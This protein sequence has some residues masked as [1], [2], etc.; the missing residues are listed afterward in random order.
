MAPSACEDT[1]IIGFQ[2]NSNDDQFDQ[3]FRRLGGNVLERHSGRRIDAFLAGEYPFLTRS[4]W[5]RRLDGGEVL[6]NRQQ[7]RSSYRMRIGDLVHFYHPEEVEPEVSR[8]VRILWQDGGVMAVFKPGNLPMHENGAYRKNTFAKLLTDLVGGEWSAVHRL[9]RETSGIVLCGANHKVRQ[10]LSDAFEA[11]SIQKEYLCIV[12]GVPI[13]RQWTNQGSLGDLVQSRIRIKKWV[14]EGGLP[15]ETGFVTEAEANGYSL[16]R[17]FPRT[18]RTNQIRIHAAHSGHWILGDKLYHP[19]EEVFLDYW[20]KGETTEFVKDKT[21][22]HR[23]CLHAAALSF[24]HPETA[25]SYRIDS[26]LPEDMQD[27]WVRLAS[28]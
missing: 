16:L 21:E 15:A 1:L 28:G 13:E 23:C 4:A 22:F 12:K 2:V 11:K 27:L 3:L 17:A 5:Q 20:E 26:P 18:G 25:R 24:V 8:D 6:V 9:D 19:S 14:V 7:I 10:T